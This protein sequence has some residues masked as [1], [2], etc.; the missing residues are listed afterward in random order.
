MH[1]Y[2]FWSHGDK[3][4]GGLF[5]WAVRKS[6]RD[7]FC[8]QYRSPTGTT[9]MITWRLFLPWGFHWER[10]SVDRRK[11]QFEVPTE[12]DVKSVAQA[13]RAGFFISKGCAY[14][15]GF[16]VTWGIMLCLGLAGETFTSKCFLAKLIF[17]ANFYSKVLA[18]GFRAGFFMFEGNAYIFRF[19]ITRGIML[20]L[21]PAKETFTF[22]YLY[23]IILVEFQIH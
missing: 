13:F 23:A 17:E 12:V 6:S 21:G 22:K 7:D 20:C 18:Q 5:T 9:K 2:R 11:S 3:S 19:V 8:I 1:M 14:I 16:L 15:F 4:L 10:I